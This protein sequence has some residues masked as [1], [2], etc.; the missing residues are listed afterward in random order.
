[1][2]H[3]GRV[4]ERTLLSPSRPMRRYER[5]DSVLELFRALAGLTIGGLLAVVL[6]Q[7]LSPMGSITLRAAGS[8][9]NDAPLAVSDSL[10]A[11]ISGGWGL[12]AGAAL[13]VSWKRHPEHARST[14]ETVWYWGTWF[15]VG[16]LGVV[17]GVLLAAVA[18][19]LAGSPRPW[20]LSS[21]VPLLAWPIGYNLVV[22]VGSLLGSNRPQP[23]QDYSPT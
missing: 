5:T 9:P 12:L 23:S 22:T 2:S 4:S 10:F 3:D 16:L 13:L 6:W 18:E 11:L 1:M 19:R 17:T 14:R 8:E 21:L 15:V 7:C 20:E